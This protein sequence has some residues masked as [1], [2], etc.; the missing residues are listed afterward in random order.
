MAKKEVDHGRRKH[1]RLYA[2]GV[3]HGYKRGLRNQHERTSLL[4]IEACKNIGDAQFYVGKRVAYVY[5]CKK[6]TPTP[7]AGKSKIRIIWGKVIRTHGNSG[8]VRAKF[9]KNMPSVAMG[10]RVRVMLYPSRI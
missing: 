6:K 2:R 7:Y 4:K 1:G 3:F 5:R 9:K 10:K 8:M